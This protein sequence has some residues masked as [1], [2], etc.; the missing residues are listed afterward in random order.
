MRTHDDIFT[1]MRRPAVP[2]TLRGRVLAAA[3]AAAGEAVA[4]VRPLLTDILWESR[5]VRLAW[6][7]AVVL[8][9]ATNL[10]LAASLPGDGNA[11]TLRRPPTDEP[12][13]ELLLE[14]YDPSPFG[15]RGLTQLGYDE[16]A[17]STRI[18]G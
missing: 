8:G 10:L 2:E 7:A 17:L 11:A 3:R 1:G 14:R 12:E 15:G 6:A 9:V 4:R 18:K 16:E 5:P 13:I